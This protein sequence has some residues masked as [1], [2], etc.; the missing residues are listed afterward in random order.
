MNQRHSS[1]FTF[2]GTLATAVLGAAIM[3]G[4]AR[5]EG[6]IGESSPFVSSK[7][8]AEV[9]AELMQDRSQVSSY[10]TEWRH[11]QGPRLA[12]NDYT[13]A[14]ATADYIASRD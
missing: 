9:Q 6:P 7:T 11:Q 5:A 3:T 10:A 2:A 8:R 12:S 14:Q 13:R 1:I 4:S